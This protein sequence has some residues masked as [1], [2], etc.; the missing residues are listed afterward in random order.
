MKSAPLNYCDER[1]G[2]CIE[3]RF[4]QKLFRKLSVYMLIFILAPIYAGSNVT[5]AIYGNLSRS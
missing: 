4:V 3:Q 5:D 2:C 1:A